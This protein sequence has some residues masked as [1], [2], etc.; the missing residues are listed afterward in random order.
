LG[1]ADDVMRRR[2]VRQHEHQVVGGLEQLL[3]ADIAGLAL[4][5]ELRRE[6]RAVVIDNVHSETM[7]TAPGNALADAP[8][9]E[10]AEGGA[11]YVRP[12]EHVVA[13][14]LPLAGA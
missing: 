14:A 8:H 10:D 12:G 11:V 7:G 13:P 3:L 1:R 5:F 4:R 6:A 9:A 2:G